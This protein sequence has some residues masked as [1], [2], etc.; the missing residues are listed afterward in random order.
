MINE[1]SVRTYVSLIGKYLFRAWCLL[2]MKCVY[3]QKK[4]LKYS[5]RQSSIHSTNYV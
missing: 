4:I 2:C 1:I 5:E 3:L